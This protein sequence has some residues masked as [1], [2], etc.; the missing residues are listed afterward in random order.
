MRV[1]RERVRPVLLGGLGRQGTNETEG[2]W[3]VWR[4]RKGE[5]EGSNN[6]GRTWDNGRDTTGHGV[7]RTR[8]CKGSQ[9]PVQRLWGFR[10][11]WRWVC[12]KT[13]T[14]KW[15]SERWNHGV[16]QDT[17]QRMNSPGVARDCNQSLGGRTPR[18]GR[19]GGEEGPKWLTRPGRSR[20]TRCHWDEGGRNVQPWAVRV[21]KCHREAA[22]NGNQDKAAHCLKP[23]SP[24]QPVGLLF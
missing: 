2:H 11:Y 7:T 18:A 23:H 15:I 6:E 8:C 22:V 1:G 17:W 13:H 16:I 14:L 10:R 12:V 21:V 4:P 20:G 3:H 5:R 19:G 9:L 24:K